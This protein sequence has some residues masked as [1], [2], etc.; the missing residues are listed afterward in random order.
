M[1]GIVNSRVNCS[2][3]P[4]SVWAKFET[5]TNFGEGGDSFVEVWLDDVSVAVIQDT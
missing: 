1:V 3:G 5:C 2:H 4:Y